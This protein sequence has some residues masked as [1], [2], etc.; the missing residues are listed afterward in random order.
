LVFAVGVAQGDALKTVAAKYPDVKFAIVDGSVDLPNVR[1]LQFNAE[2]G[3]FLAGYL[4]ALMS[5]TKKIGFVGGEDIDLIRK[6]LYGY[7]AGAKAADP[8]VEVLPAKYVGNWDSLDTGHADAQQLF[9][10]GADIVYHAAGRAGLGVINAAKEQD[11]YAIGVDG[12][13]DGVA[14]GHVLTSMIKHVDEAVYATIQDT[15]KGGF[16]SGTK[17]YDL[18]SGGVGLSPMTYTKAKIGPE[19]LAKV[20][21]IAADIKAGKLKVPTSEDELKAFNPPKN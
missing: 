20:D 6:F 10:S 21:K 12:D 14:Q 17:V 9:G 15:I 13:Q 16:T 1:G 18:A 11:K 19:K 2:Q 4:A 5:T 3:S 7:S 8:T